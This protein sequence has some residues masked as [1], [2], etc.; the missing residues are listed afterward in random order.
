[1]LLEIFYFCLFSKGECWD[2]E[3][4]PQYICAQ[5]LLGSRLLS[6]QVC[7]LFSSIKHRFPHTCI[8]VSRYQCLKITVMLPGYPG[9]EKL[10]GLGFCGW[11]RVSVQA[12]PKQ[13]HGVGGK[14]RTQ[15]SRIQIQPE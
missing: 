5:G 11:L 9:M 7:L 2:R 12:I 3:T 1:M 4:H 13:L 14:F 8:F 6:P 15:G 10:H